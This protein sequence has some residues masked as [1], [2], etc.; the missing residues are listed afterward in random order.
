[1]V[2]VA[3]VAAWVVVACAAALLLGR[4]LAVSGKSDRW[5]HGHREVRDLR[6]LH[7]VPSAAPAAHGSRREAA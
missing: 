2:I 1:M 7:A 6:Y 5:R 4:S 3:L